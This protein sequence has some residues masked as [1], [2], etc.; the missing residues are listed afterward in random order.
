MYYFY[1]LIHYCFNELSS[2]QKHFIVLCVLTSLPVCVSQAFMKH[3]TQR[4][5]E[6][7]L[8]NFDLAEYRQVISDLAIQIYQQLIKCMENILQPMIG[9]CTLDQCF[10]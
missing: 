9:A 6:H 3:N 8:S 7:C 2:W 5:N 10:V 1:K 4:Q